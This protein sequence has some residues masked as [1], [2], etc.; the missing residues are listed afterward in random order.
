IV[1]ISLFAGKVNVRCVT[2]LQLLVA[3]LLGWILM[4][5]AGENMPEFSWVWLSA[6]VGLGAA[7]CLIQL[8]M[9]WAQ[10]E[11]SPTRAT[12]IYASEP[13]WAGI[14][15]RI[16]GDRLPGLALLGGALI[17]AGVITSELKP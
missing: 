4:P 12:L 8:T 3:G 11:V 17:I 14:L 5:V 15:G 10:K 13:V 2:T 9:N 1:L 7:S 6:A 16:A